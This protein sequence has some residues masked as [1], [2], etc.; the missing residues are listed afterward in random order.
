[1]VARAL[2]PDLLCPH[3]EPEEIKIVLDV[4]YLLIGAAFLEGCVLYAVACDRL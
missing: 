1:M 3:A 4:V 2:A